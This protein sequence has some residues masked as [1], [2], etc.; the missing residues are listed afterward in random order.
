MVSARKK[1]EETSNK[2][3]KN[4]SFNLLERGLCLSIEEN[5]FLTFP[6]RAT[7]LSVHSGMR[8]TFRLVPRNDSKE[9][10]EGGGGVK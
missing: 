4:Y 8:E 1:E 9:I 10:R 6:H 3:G 2:I 7:L 5:L